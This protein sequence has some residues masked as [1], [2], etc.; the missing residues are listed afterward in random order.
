MRRFRGWQARV[1]LLASEWRRYSPLLS[2][3]TVSIRCGTIV[4]AYVLV[5]FR[6]VWDT[7]ER[8]IDVAIGDGQELVSRLIW[9]LTVLV[10]VVADRAA[11]LDQVGVTFA[12]ERPLAAAEA[13][14]VQ[15]VDV[16]LRVGLGVGREHQA[17][18]RREANQ[19]DREPNQR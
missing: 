13:V 4:L 3:S 11:N 8:P 9:G 5:L 2:T 6:K 1:Y 14:A 10:D 15:I 16:V 7:R 12:L 19:V 18:K 17:E